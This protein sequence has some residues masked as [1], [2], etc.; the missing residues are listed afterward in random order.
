MNPAEA[1]IAAYDNGLTVFG[2]NKVQELCEKKQAVEEVI[3]RDRIEWHL[4]GHLQTNKV[5]YVVGNV[6]LIHSVDSVKLAEAIDRESAKK[7]V[8]TDILL[9]VNVAEEESKFGFT[10]DQAVE[11]AAEIGTLKN[12]RLKGLMTVAPFTD[13]PENNRVYFK[14]LK[15]LSVDI[16]LKNIDN[17]S[18]DV[19]SMGMTGDFETAIE[20]GA[21]FIRV[22]TGLFG[23]RDY[24]KQ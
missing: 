6:C 14:K 17:V 1:V 18:M 11:A 22:G 8:I 20:E 13:D 12:V 5:K 15:D 4:I 16:K 23:A 19:L 3:G 10:P 9:E 24:S 2:E 21:S 7:N